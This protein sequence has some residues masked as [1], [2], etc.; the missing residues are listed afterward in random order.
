[1]KPSLFLCFTLLMLLGCKKI[2]TNSP[3]ST[4]EATH[5]ASIIGT[6]QL[7]EESNT[8]CKEQETERCE[9]S[10]CIVYT[11]TA[12]TWDFLFP[13][14]FLEGNHYTGT[15]TT[16]GDTITLTYDYDHR[17]TEVCRFVISGSNLA[18][19]EGSPWWRMMR[20][21]ESCKWVAKFD[22]H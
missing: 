6:W 19:L 7:V 16:K 14:S 5:S 4:N 18:L 11:F 3:A 20:Y 15:Y 1:M 22:R 9:G 10:S 12:T 8:G 2:E 21:R 17:R 13:G